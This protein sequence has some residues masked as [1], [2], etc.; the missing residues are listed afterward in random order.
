MNDG[1]LLLRQAHPH[2]MEGEQ[3]TS[4]VFMPNSEDQ[5]RMSA[6]DGDQI[7]PADAHAHYTQVLQKQSHGVWALAKQE[8]DRN[9]VPASP[10][11][12]P[13]SPSHAKID[14]SS[15]PQSAWRRTAKK[16][17]ALAIARGCQFKPAQV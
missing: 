13:D 2:F 8:A 7:S 16:L 9:G 4:Q 15:L 17:K 5:G 10:D 1:T 6:Y 12:L 14:F 11:P 3:P